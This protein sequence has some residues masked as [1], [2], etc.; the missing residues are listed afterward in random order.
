MLAETLDD[1]A[2]GFADLDVASLQDYRSLSGN[3]ALARI[4]LLI[5]GFPLLR[6]EWDATPGR[7]ARFADLLRILND[8][9]RVGIHVAFTADRPGAIPTA[10]S[11]VVPRRIVLRMSDENGYLLMDAPGDVLDSSSPAGRAIVDGHETQIAILGGDR[12]AATQAAALDR[13]A[14]QLRDR[15]VAEVSPVRSLPAEIAAETL[16]DEV[17]DRPVLGV[18]D[19]TL[20]PLGFDPRGAM[21]LIGPPGSGRSTAL[22][23][24]A[25]SLQ[26]WHPSIA[27]Y[28]IGPR[29]SA[30]AAAVPWADNA[31]E[32]D[33]IADLARRLTVAVAG[34]QD[35]GRIAVVVESIAELLST[36]ADAPVVELIRAVKRSDQYLVAEAESSAWISSWPLLAEVKNTRRGIL[37][38]PD[39]AEGDTFLRATLPRVPRA[40]FPPGRGYLVGAGAPVRVQLPLPLVTSHPVTAPVTTP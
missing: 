36:A 32:P 29:R 31:T 11:S 3:A 34:E 17:D 23:W 20:A 28:R 5:D 24:L 10:V 33:A 40:E 18:S 19:D 16:P 38:Q 1:R 4:L 37:L 30:L 25:E 6:S 21:A 15:G 13:L 8:G 14:E 26:R 27:L 22:L 2:R 7:A 35:P 12:A 9:R 39:P